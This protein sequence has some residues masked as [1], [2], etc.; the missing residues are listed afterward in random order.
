MAEA[1]ATELCHGLRTSKVCWSL[2]SLSA[3]VAQHIGFSL[4]REAVSGVCSVQAPQHREKPLHNAT[5]S[6]GHVNEFHGPFILL[7]QPEEVVVGV[8]LPQLA[9][10]MLSSAKGVCLSYL[11]TWDIILICATCLIL[12][13]KQTHWHMAGAHEV[14]QTHSLT[15]PPTL[16][17]SVTSNS[18]SY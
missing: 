5:A 2:W 3:L 8:H 4:K 9:G 10:L 6:C 14:L 18:I 13:A 16:C 12:I 11:P 15:P 17:A 7:E 1:Q